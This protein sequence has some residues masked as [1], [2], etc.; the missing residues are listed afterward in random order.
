MSGD[1]C[2]I[3]TITGVV[4]SPIAFSLSDKN[5][6]MVST[7]YSAVVIQ[8]IVHIEIENRRLAFPVRRCRFFTRDNKTDG[9]GI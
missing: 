4:G 5:R 3:P 8:D 7:I 2:R 1:I 6:P 9:S